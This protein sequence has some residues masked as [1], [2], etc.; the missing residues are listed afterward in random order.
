MSSDNPE[1]F[2]RWFVLNLVTKGFLAM[3][4]PLLN[5]LQ[6][7]KPPLSKMKTCSSQTLLPS[8]ITPSPS[9]RR[10]VQ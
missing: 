4:K 6:A 2:T 5:R 7:L 8:T 9:V 10:P 3:Y 1:P